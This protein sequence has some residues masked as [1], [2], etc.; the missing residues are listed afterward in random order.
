VAQLLPGVSAYCVLFKIR[1]AVRRPGFSSY[2]GKELIADG[3]WVEHKFGAKAGEGDSK[4]DRVVAI[5]FFE[6]KGVIQ[7]DDVRV[8]PR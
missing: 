8:V 6:G 7:I 5:I 4:G 1:R 2:S 3:K